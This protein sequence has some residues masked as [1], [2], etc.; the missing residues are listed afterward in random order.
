MNHQLHPSL[1]IR[2]TL[3]HKRYIRKLREIRLGTTEQ[4]QYVVT[5]TTTMYPLFT[6]SSIH[7]TRATNVILV[8]SSIHW[9]LRREPSFFMNNIQL[10]TRYGT[11]EWSNGESEQRQHVVMMM[12]NNDDDVL[13][14]HFCMN[15]LLFTCLWTTNL[16]NLI[17]YVILSHRSTGRFLMNHPPFADYPSSSSTPCTSSFF[18]NNITL[19]TR[20]TR[21]G[22]K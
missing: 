3:L 14:V 15:H 6:S 10:V 4:R 8:S 12:M 11:E 7:W 22:I 9:T 2:W 19:V 1:S 13:S 16:T 21:V 17:I 5:M 20:V 18:T